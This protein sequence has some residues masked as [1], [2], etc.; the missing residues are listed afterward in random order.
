MMISMC[1]P[2]MGEEASRTAGHDEPG[3]GAIA[4]L[5]MSRFQAVHRQLKRA[6]AGSPGRGRDAAAVECECYY[7]QL[8]GQARWVARA[9]CSRESEQ[10]PGNCSDI[11]RPCLPA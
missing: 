1:A 8:G 2:R 9:R 6:R 3:A 10:W 11:E 4:E 5:S 7:G